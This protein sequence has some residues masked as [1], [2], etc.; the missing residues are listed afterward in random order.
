[1]LLSRDY[2]NPIIP[3]HEHKGGGGGWGLLEKGALLQDQTSIEGLLWGRVPN[4][5]GVAQ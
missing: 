5:E 3:L 1:M 4:G 2:L